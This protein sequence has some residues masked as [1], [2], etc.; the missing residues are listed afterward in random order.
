MS[1]VFEQFVKKQLLDFCVT[2]RIIPDSQYGFLPGRS[3]IWQFLSVVNDC[4]NALDAGYS[5]HALFLDVSKAFDRVDHSLLVERCKS[6]GLTGPSLQWIKSYIQGGR[7]LPRLRDSSQFQSAFHQVF[8]KGL[9]LVHSSLLY[10]FQVFP[11]PSTRVHLQCLPT[12]H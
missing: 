1:K 2:H 5:V 3:T 11:L 7:L 4:H 9:S 8:H 6:I 12:T 10:I